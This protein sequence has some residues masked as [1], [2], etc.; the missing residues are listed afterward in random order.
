MRLTNFFLSLFRRTFKVRNYVANTLSTYRILSS[1]LLIFFLFTDRTGLFKWF[2]ALSFFTDAADGLIARRMRTKSVFGAR[3]DSIGD[4]IT[5]AIAIAGIV[6]LFPWFI[7]DQQIAISIVLALLV[8]QIGVAL[9]KFRKM[10]AYHTYL[11]K[12]A[13]VLQAAWLLGFFFFETPLYMLFYLCI[14][15]TC[16]QLAEEIVIT[17]VLSVYTVD[18]KGVYW[19]V[20]KN[21]PGN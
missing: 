15:V 8:L 3:L 19:A 6:K 21:R 13:A 9:I 1:P 4:D 17:L 11:A 16:L 14:L 7:Y 12:L 20:K 2:L 10:T 5:V 18:V